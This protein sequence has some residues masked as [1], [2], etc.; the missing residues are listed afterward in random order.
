MYGTL[1]AAVAFLVWAWLVNLALLVGVEVNR[2]V[3]Q[4]RAGSP[5]RAPAQRPRAARER[6]EPRAYNRGSRQPAGAPARR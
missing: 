6:D 5:T 3:E 2:D 4:R 1:G